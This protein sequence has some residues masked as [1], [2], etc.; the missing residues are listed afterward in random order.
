MPRA[1][2]SDEELQR[3]YPKAPP[4]PTERERV[5]AALE[6][7]R[8]GLVEAKRKLADAEREHRFHLMQ[9]VDDMTKKH[10]GW[11]AGNRP[12]IDRLT[13]ES[14]EAEWLVTDLQERL[15]AI[16]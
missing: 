8:L 4:P 2:L 14:R 13:W 12:V 5:T 10:N 11:V 16:P 1:K 3:L 6:N 15:K 9:G 7:A